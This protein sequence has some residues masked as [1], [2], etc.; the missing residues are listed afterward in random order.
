MYYLPVDQRDEIQLMGIWM[1][2]SCTTK[3]R[4]FVILCKLVF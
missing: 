3:V 1:Y 4:I 2:T